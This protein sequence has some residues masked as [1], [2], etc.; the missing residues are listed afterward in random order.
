M[1]EHGRRERLVFG[2]EVE[3]GDSLR[4]MGRSYRVTRLENYDHPDG[5]GG[6]RIAFVEGQERGFMT[7]FD[8]HTVTVAT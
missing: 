6:A 5:L 1:S 2:R 4:F 7:V 3:P 8:E